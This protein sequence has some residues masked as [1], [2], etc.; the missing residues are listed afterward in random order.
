LD[1]GYDDGREMMIHHPSK[2]KPMYFLGNSPRLHCSPCPDSQ[3]FGLV[4]YLNHEF[5]LSGFPIC[6][7][8]PGL[9]PERPAD[10]GPAP[11][12]GEDTSLRLAPAS[13][14]RKSFSLFDSRFHGSCES[15]QSLPLPRTP[16]E[17]SF[18][19]Y[20]CRAGGTFYGDEAAH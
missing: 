14:S 6:H 16:L 12:A 5:A 7:R 15:R 19:R 8:L 17:K 10:L 2:H 9:R 3:N 11:D 13:S 18:R 4:P 1:V 20:A